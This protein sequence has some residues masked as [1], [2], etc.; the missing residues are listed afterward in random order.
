M[1]ISSANWDSPMAMPGAMGRMRRACSSKSQMNSR[2]VPSFVKL[3]P[4]LVNTV[5]ELGS[6]RSADRDCPR[7]ADNPGGVV[8]R[9]LVGVIACEVDPA[10]LLCKRRTLDR[11]HRDQ[12]AA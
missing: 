6:S 2:P 12:T 3:R 4:S 8:G 7:P 5:I 10:R 11:S 1:S 9:H